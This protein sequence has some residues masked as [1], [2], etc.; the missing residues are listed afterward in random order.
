MPLRY[1]CDD[2]HKQAVTHIRESRRFGSMYTPY[3]GKPD[4][5]ATLFSRSVHIWSKTIRI[6]RGPH[7]TT[8]CDT[9]TD[10]DRSYCTREKGLPTQSTAHR[11]IDLR[12]HTQFPFRAN[13]WSSRRKPSSCRWP[14]TRLTGPI[15]TSMRSVRSI[16][17]REGQSIGP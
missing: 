14:T 8:I 16:L 5:H 12:V 1:L 11:L 2:C 17:A 15:N 13:Q 3:R 4:Q 7:T 6:S 9:S 10:L